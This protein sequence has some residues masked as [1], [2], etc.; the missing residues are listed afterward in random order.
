MYFNEGK[1]NW[2]KIFVKTKDNATAEGFDENGHYVNREFPDL[3]D[4]VKDTLINIINRPVEH[5]DLCDW[6]RCPCGD[7]QDKARIMM[8]IK[9]QREQ[10]YSSPRRVGEY[11]ECDEE[12][13]KKPRRK[14]E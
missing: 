13:P 10:S 4:A 8:E 12:A 9:T 5:Q 11:R 3:V 7:C 1:C 2:G 14:R 6:W